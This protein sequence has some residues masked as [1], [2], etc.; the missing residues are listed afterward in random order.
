M[1]DEL[2]SRVRRSQAEFEFELARTT[3]V[4]RLLSLSQQHQNTMWSFAVDAAEMVR[5]LEEN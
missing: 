4:Y 2:I 5:E 1:F 3:D